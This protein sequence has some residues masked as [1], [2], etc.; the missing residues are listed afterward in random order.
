MSE[1]DDERGGDDRLHER[2]RAVERALTGGD[3]A[4]ADLEPAAE[5][6]AE[7]ECLEDRIADLE[8][9][10]EELEAA[11]QAVR[12]YVGS[13]RAVNREVERRADLALAAA[14]EARTNVA[15]A[16][17]TDVATE[18]WT[19]VVNDGDGDRDGSDGAREPVG[20]PALAAALPEDRTE[21]NATSGAI[22]TNGAT[23]DEAESAG[24]STGSAAL[25][26]LREV[27]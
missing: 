22:G 19:D 1:G 5:A 9:R 17:R 2:L 15:T 13:V 6:A 7:R 16:S 21:R 27:L 12:G 3:R 23:D 18:S 26:R 11:T 20:D 10:V 14:T 24:R 8:A 4:V 25:D